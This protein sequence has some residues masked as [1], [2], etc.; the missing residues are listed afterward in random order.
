MAHAAGNVA[1]VLEVSNGNGIAGM[2]ARLRDWL[3]RQGVRA[4]RLSNQRPFAQEHTA[5]QYRPGHAEA[6]Q[7]LADVLPAALRAT[8]APTPGLRS[9]VRVVLGRDW[10][11][12]AA[13]LEHDICKAPP[14][15]VAAAPAV[16]APP[17]H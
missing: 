1:A 11:R 13:C 7:R 6:A 16:A 15:T 2:G 9:D 3:A 12:S 10:V 4:G 17:R 5:I 14:T 8:P